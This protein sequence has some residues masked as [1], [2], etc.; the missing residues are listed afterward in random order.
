M[1]KF[2]LKGFPHTG[3][4]L[5]GFTLVMVA[6]MFMVFGCS[7]TEKVRVPP[8]VELKT[9]HTIGV[10]EFSTN[11]ED[12]LKPYVTQN[13]I[14]NIQSAQ[15]GTRILELGD[16]DQLLRS[17]GHSRLNPET[18][19]SIGRKYNVDAVILGHLQVSEIKPKIKVFAAA[20]A[21]NAKAY[22]EAALRTRILET[23]SGATLWT[24][25]TTGKTQVARINLMEGGPI[26]FGVSDPKEKYGKLVPELVY[27]NTTDFRSRYEYRTVE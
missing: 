7:H 20:K 22:I 8:R 27:V 24:R 13:F 14:Q 3:F 21:L 16:K 5:L 4:K 6:T 15:P 10:I 9:Y 11:A 17:L 25:A 19:Q 12:T 18:I 1:K 23:D 2:H 26:S